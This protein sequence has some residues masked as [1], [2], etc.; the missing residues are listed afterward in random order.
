MA[1]ILKINTIKPGEIVR[2]VSFAEVNGDGEFEVL[3]DDIIFLAITSET[4][5]ELTI[6]GGNTVLG[7]GDKKITL[8]KNENNYLYL[9]SGPYA[10]CENGKTVIRFNVANS[11]HIAVIQAV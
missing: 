11:L 8:N 4:A 1:T 3:K 7:G 2:S 9:E 6:Y 5:N 10:Q